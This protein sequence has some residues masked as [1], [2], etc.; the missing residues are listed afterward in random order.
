MMLPLIV[1]PCQRSSR[2]LDIPKNQKFPDDHRLRERSNYSSVRRGSFQSSYPRYRS[3]AS[4]FASSCC[5]F[6]PLSCCCC[7]LLPAGHH[8]ATSPGFLRSRFVT[9]ALSVKPCAVRVPEPRFQSGRYN[10]VLGSPENGST[11]FLEHTC[12]R[13][14]HTLT[15]RRGQIP[16][17][18]CDPNWCPLLID[19]HRNRV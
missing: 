16:V 13:H 12:S 6:L 1:L 15:L 19:T 4:L 8:G 9:F 3:P 2:S 17:R 10:W 11:T 18:L 14:T 7:L 5:C